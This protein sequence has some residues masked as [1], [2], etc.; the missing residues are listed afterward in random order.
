MTK[1]E[2]IEFKKIKATKNELE[3]ELGDEYENILN[4]ITHILLENEDV[5]DDNE[6]N[7]GYNILSDNLDYKNYISNLDSYQLSL[8]GEDV[9]QSCENGNKYEEL[10]STQEQL[11]QSFKPSRNVFTSLKLYLKRSSGISNLG[12]YIVF[13]RNDSVV[14]DTWLVG[15][16]RMQNI[17]TDGG[18]VTFNCL[19]HYELDID[20][21]YY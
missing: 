14:G 1:D 13:I 17:P 4:P 10:Y 15:I 5:N 11:A 9:D 16:G 18:W 7:I 8:S 21:S 20:R 2:S 6:A 12:W 19:K 3:I